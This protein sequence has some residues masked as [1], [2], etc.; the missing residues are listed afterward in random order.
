MRTVRRIGRGSGPVFVLLVLM[1]P[2]MK[3]GVVF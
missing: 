1:W 3:I 2:E